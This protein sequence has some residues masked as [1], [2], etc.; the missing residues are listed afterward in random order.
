VKVAKTRVDLRSVRG[1]QERHQIGEMVWVEVRKDDMLDVILPEPQLGQA[2]GDAPPEV[3]D[4][5]HAFA[6]DQ[7]GGG[8]PS[9][10]QLAGSGA[11]QSEA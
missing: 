9:R 6:V 5:A 8:D 11:Q 10:T 7:D 2:V 1:M 3:E 4:D